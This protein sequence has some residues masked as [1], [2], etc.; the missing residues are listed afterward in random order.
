MMG[1]P[2]NV[3][4]YTCGDDHSVLASTTEPGSTRKK[5]SWSIAYHCVREG[6][7]NDERRTHYVNT[8]E[9]EADVLTKLLPGGEKRRGFVRDLL[10]HIY[11]S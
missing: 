7:A 1:I 8:H 5:N 4:C 2:L 10:Y 11:M 6:V 9:N 3:P